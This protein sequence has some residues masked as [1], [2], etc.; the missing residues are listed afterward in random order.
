MEARGP[1]SKLRLTTKRPSKAGLTKLPD[2]GTPLSCPQD[3]GQNS[4]LRGI[5]QNVQKALH[6]TQILFSVWDRE[7]ATK[8]RARG[9]CIP[10]APPTAPLP[11]T[12][13]TF[14]LIDLVDHTA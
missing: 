13:R 11:W 9:T 2:M 6:L 4:P 10:P 14:I 7:G 12:S 3:Q 5:C 8:T 1:F